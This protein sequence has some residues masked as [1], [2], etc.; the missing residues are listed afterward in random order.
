MVGIQLDAKI[1]VIDILQHFEHRMRSGNHGI[2]EALHR[3]PQP[4]FFGGLQALA[5]A[6][7]QGFPILL[8][9]VA[10]RHMIALLDRRS[11]GI[12]LPGSRPARQG[13]QSGYNSA[14]DPFCRLRGLFKILETVFPLFTA[15]GVP[16]VILK[17][18]NIRFQSNGSGMLSQRP[19]GF[20]GKELI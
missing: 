11:R 15:A 8:I 6:F 2:R 18:K 17:N 14:A 10:G 13:H 7:H 1:R 3:H 9:E 20:L 5:V 12:K 16:A 4:I 19:A